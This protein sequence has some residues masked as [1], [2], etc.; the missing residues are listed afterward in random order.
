MHNYISIIEISELINKLGDKC[1]N[2]YVHTAML[3][4]L[5]IWIN[6]SIN[7]YN[8]FTCQWKKN[9]INALDARYTRFIFFVK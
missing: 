8:M 5:H 9:L 1:L 2:N 3:K 7:E 6:T 4:C